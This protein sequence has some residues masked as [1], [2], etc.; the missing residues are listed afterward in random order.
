[1]AGTVWRMAWTSSE[2]E[3]SWEREEM[4]ERSRASDLRRRD[5]ALAALAHLIRSWKERAREREREVGF[6]EEEEKRRE[7]YGEDGEL[8]LWTQE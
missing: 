6:E 8:G 2:S 5:G 7:R 1:M 4:V 3:S